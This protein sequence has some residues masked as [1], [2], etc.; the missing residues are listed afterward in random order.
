M[1]PYSYTLQSAFGQPPYSY[2]LL[3]GNL[4]SGLTMNGSGD[5]T[6]TASAVGQFPFQVLATD[7]SQPAQ[8][9]SSNYTLNVVIR[10]D[11]Y[12]GL[13]AAPL[14]GCTPTNYF[15]LQKVTGRWYY[16]DP[17]CNAFYQFSMYASYP[18]FI[19]S[20]IL[21][22]RYGGDNAK[23]ANHSL[24]REVA[25]GFN[26]QDIFYS[27]YMLPVDTSTTGAAPTKVPFPSS[28]AR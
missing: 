23:W 20:D 26:T 15:Q 11:T 4:P 3:S 13:T 2:Q 25:Y 18:G 12:S 14:P 9:Q 6:G 19:F 24:Q 7:S 17:N 1:E 5:L 10:L 22:S 21:K 28:S 16:A 8:Q 27:N